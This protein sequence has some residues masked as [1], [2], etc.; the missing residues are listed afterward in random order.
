MNKWIYPKIAVPCLVLLCFGFLSITSSCKNESST[1][2]EKWIDLKI[3]DWPQIVMTNKVVF[4]DTTYTDFASSFLVDTGED[5]I[6]VTCKHVFAAFSAI[7]LFT[8]DFRG[9]LESWKMY[10]K[11]DREC[12]IEAGQLINRNPGEMAALPNTTNN[13]D[14]LAFKIKTGNKN[15][16]PLKIGDGSVRAGEML[17]NL[18]WT[19]DQTDGPPKLYS[20]KVY[21][22]VG[23]QIFMEPVN[24]TDNAA[25]LSGSP[26]FNRD[27]HLVGISSGETGNLARACSV[28]YLMEVLEKN[29]AP[30]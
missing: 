10:P 9:R 7:G 11:N 14:W 20:F 5:T 18:G 6:G 15:I 26:I 3:K 30:K 16:Y 13:T 2:R 8:V 1:K 23:N 22:V 27:G 17:Y 12:V 19:I 28:F 25:G 21:R 24:F 29:H 4:D